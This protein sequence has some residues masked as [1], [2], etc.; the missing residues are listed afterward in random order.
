M[1]EVVEKIKKDFNLDLDEMAKAGLHFGHKTSRIHPKI[2][3]YLYGE[4]NNVNIIDLEKTKQ[5]LQEALKFIQ[6]LI[7]E[8]KIL[9]LIGT[10]IQIKDLIKNVA[11][12]C[13]LPYVNQR[14][15]GG[16]F[17]NFEIIKKRIEKFKDLEKKESRRRIRK[18]Y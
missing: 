6:Q 12:D 18:I 7:K 9:L 10:K 1:A 16:T 8:N 2:K 17:T 11:I 4:R 14:W 3:P 15:L 13:A 5:K